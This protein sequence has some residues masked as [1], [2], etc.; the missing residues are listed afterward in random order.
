MSNSY[1]VAPPTGLV[2]QFGTNHRWVVLAVGVAAQASFAAAFSG[3]PVLGVLMRHSYGLT[4]GE[5]GVVLG[6]MALGVGASEIL[7]GLLTDWLGDRRVLLA[8]LLAMGGMLA[9]MSL[10]VLP[11]G[12]HPAG[13]TML[14]LSFVLVGALGAS[15]NSSSGRAIMTWFTDGRRGFAMSI[16]QTAIPAGGALGAAILPRLA[17]HGG[18]GLVYAVLAALC[19][20][21][22][23]ATW[24]W[25]HEAPVDKSAPAKGVGADTRSPLRRPDIWR[26]ALASGLLT[27]PQ[28]AVLTFAGVYLHDVRHLG[29]ATI[30][31]LLIVV[32]L[33]GG[34]LRVWS[35]RQSDKYRNRRSFVR[36]FGL[37]AGLAML[38]VAFAGQ[39]PTA[40][41]MGLFGLSGLFANAWHGVA[42]T[43]IA[44]M[45][46]AARAGSAIGL[47][48]TTIF[49]SAFLTPLLIPFVLASTSWPAV[50]GVIALAALVAVPLAPGPVK[51][52]LRR[53]A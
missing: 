50:W 49:A 42:F 9:V 36:A 41:V 18:F 31:E 51:A 29:I 45:A 14:A 28:I 30:A 48:G 10:F 35:G 15:V 33:G 21:S 3:L 37:L 53:R 2:R 47:E 52:V 17:T 34:V 22:A 38:G 26:L 12:R 8:G 25:L 23:L 1:K 19:L 40:V 27:A 16:R 5:L 39:W 4:T 32:Q 7:W 11:D 46:G 24:I 20:A 13:A 43:E 44:V 6:C